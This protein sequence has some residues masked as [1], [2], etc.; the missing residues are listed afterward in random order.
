MLCAVSSDRAATSPGRAVLPML[1]VSGSVW[2][3]ERVDR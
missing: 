3:L 1:T 2:M